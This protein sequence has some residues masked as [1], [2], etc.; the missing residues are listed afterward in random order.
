MRPLCLLNADAE[1][2]HCNSV[3]SSAR[4]QTED[5]EPVKEDGAKA[6]SEVTHVAATRSRVWT[7][8]IVFDEKCFFFNDMI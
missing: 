5:A 6:A 4:L 7:D 3:V 2:G 8:F 1:G